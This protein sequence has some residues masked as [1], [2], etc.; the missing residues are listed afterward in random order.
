MV[1]QSTFLSFRPGLQTHRHRS[2]LRDL[3]VPIYTGCAILALSACGTR[4]TENETSCLAAVGKEQADIYVEQCIHVSPAT[5]PP[6]NVLNSCA[7]IIGEIRRSCAFFD[8]AELAQPDLA[9]CA[10]YLDPTK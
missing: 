4:A 2:Q 6:C 10:E 5:H 7:L 8:E 3:V 1:M 9:F